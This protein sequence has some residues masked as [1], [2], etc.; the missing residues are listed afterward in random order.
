MHV[1][2]KA[3]EPRRV[4]AVLRVDPPRV[5]LHRSSPRKRSS[6]V[7][8]HVAPCVPTHRV[9]ASGKACCAAP[10]SATAAGIRLD[11]WLAVP[12]VDTREGWFPV[13]C[14]NGWAAGSAVAGSS[15]AE[16]YDLGFLPRGVALTVEG[17]H[18]E[19]GVLYCS[20]RLTVELEGGP[21]DTPFAPVSMGVALVSGVGLVLC[22]RPKTRVKGLGR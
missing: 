9:S 6:P 4:H 13:E 18:F 5:A 2:L 12:V 15:G 20:E 7:A 16:S 8:A 11:P 14:S 21:F 10:D 19:D 17:E 3:E 22:G 1:A